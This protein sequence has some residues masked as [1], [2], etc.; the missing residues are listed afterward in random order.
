MYETPSRDSISAKLQSFHEDPQLVWEA[1]AHHHRDP[2][3]C[4]IPSSVVHLHPEIELELDGGE[5]DP[6]WMD[7]ETQAARMAD[8]EAHKGVPDVVQAEQRNFDVQEA[9]SDDPAAEIKE[10]LGRV[11]NLDAT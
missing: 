9:D 3:A 1:S 6:E 10:W 2:S 8:F 4:P 7:P 5:I 11:Q